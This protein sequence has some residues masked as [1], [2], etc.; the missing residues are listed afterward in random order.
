[1]TSCGGLVPV[2][3][4]FLRRRIG[5]IGLDARADLHGTSPRTGMTKVKSGHSVSGARDKEGGPSKKKIPL[6]HRK[7]LRRLADEE[8]AVGADLVAFRIDA[9]LGRRVIVDHGALADA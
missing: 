8:L 9:D 3:H 1:M 4:A 7:L 5:R 6:R 2:T